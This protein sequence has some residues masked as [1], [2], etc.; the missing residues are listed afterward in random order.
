[1]HFV[2]ILK[3]INLS[4]NKKNNKRINSQKKKKKKLTVPEL[5]P[6]LISCSLCKTRKIDHTPGLIAE[7]PYVTYR[8]KISASSAL[9]GSTQSAK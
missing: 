6:A 3:K 1:L 8:T 5:E 2:K 9:S 7:S 4:V